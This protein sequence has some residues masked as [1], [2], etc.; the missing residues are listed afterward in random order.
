MTLD[1]I[2]RTNRKGINRLGLQLL[3]G[4]VG[5]L[6]G[7]AS[8]FDWNVLEDGKSVLAS[9]FGAALGFLILPLVSRLR[10]A[11]RGLEI[12]TS[13]SVAIPFLGTVTFKLTD[14][15]RRSGWKIFVEASTRIATQSLPQR[16]G[17]IREALTSLYGLF[18]IVRT[19]LKEIP[20][21]PP[22]L[23]S[24]DFTM[25][26]YAIR[27]LNDGLRPCLARWHPRLS[28]WEKNGIPE[29]QWLLAALCRRDIEATRLKVLAY[30]WGLGGMLRVARLGDLLPELPVDQ[31]PPQLIS[32]AELSKAE[33]GLEPT[34]SEAQ[35]TAGW[36]VFVEVASRIA[37]QPLDQESGRLREAMTS[38]H[39]LFQTVR[40]ELKDMAPTRHRTSDGRATIEG[41]SLQILNAG[42]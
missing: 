41:I 22:P 4:L 29:S 12:E 25:E 8:V 14:V 40:Q 11:A 1:R 24:N 16:A 13:P 26:S 20:P 19:E 23:N 6:V 9:A 27:I 39:Q 17:V 37:T 28:A 2:E 35:A 3:L 42:V 31:Q 32:D 33:Q 7:F 30:T 18:D 36:H 15:H 10:S 38:L 34:L 21:S 5:G